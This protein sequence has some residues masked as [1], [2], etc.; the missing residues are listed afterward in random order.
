MVVN[1]KANEMVVKASD[2]RQVIG[3]QL[4]KGK[5]IVTNQRIYF[6]SQEN[7]SAHANR[8]INPDQILEVIY[9]SG[10]KLFSKGLNVVT[11]NGDN[12]LFLVKKRN[13]FGQLINK[14]Y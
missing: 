9:I 13:E 3:N 12:H 14:M 6:I 2:S 5:F 10:K 11:K 7:E 8:E 4:I 1:L